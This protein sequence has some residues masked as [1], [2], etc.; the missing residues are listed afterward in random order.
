MRK[1]LKKTGFSDYVSCF[2]DSLD[3][4][5]NKTYSDWKWL[6]TKCSRCQY[7]QTKKTIKRILTKNYK[8]ALE[9]G[10]GDGIWTI[11][12]LNNCSKIDAIDISEKMLKM[13]KK[14]LQNKL[15]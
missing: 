5:Q 10:P 13:A 15:F 14:R 11:L 1:T 3:K 8:K 12:F 9:I 4:S 2:Y 7:M 6:R